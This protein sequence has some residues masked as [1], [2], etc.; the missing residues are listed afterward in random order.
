MAVYFLTCHRLECLS[1]NLFF[2]FKS[3][4]NVILIPSV[5]PSTVK[6]FPFSES[7]LGSRFSI[8]VEDEL[9]VEVEDELSVE[10]EDELS[11]ESE[12]VVESESVVESEVVAESET[13]VKPVADVTPEAE[14][15]QPNIIKIDAKLSI[16]LLIIFFHKNPPLIFGSVYTEQRNHSIPRINSQHLA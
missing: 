7:V 11:V 8:V 6:Y 10:V 2:I 4:F 3:S 13:V 16:T 15:L 1:R 5:V 14:L 9:S 12:V